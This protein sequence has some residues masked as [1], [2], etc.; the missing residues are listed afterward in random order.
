MRRLSY[1]LCALGNRSCMPIYGFLF[2]VVGYVGGGGLG[3][4][5]EPQ[6]VP[7]SLIFAI[8]FL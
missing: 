5:T 6:I 4:A 2:L 3:V 7:F 8:P 1:T